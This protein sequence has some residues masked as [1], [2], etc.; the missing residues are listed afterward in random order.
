[1]GVHVSSPRSS[2]TAAQW[3]QNLDDI[4]V[5]RPSPS[6]GKSRTRFTLLKGDACSATDITRI[7]KTPSNDPNAIDGESGSFTAVVPKN[8]AITGLMKV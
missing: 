6:R 3:R 7:D 2:R 8:T 1:V 5:P 4:A